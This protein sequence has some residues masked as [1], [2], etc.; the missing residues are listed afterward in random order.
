MIRNT[1]YILIVKSQLSTG[2]IIFCTT[3]NDIINVIII[4]NIIIIIIIIIIISI[5]VALGFFIVDVSASLLE[6]QDG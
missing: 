1:E 4:I 2:A 3:L 6:N 5:H